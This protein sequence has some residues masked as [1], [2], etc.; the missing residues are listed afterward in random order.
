MSALVHLSAKHKLDN[1]QHLPEIARHIRGLSQNASAA[2]IEIGRSLIQAK[3][4]ARHGE[5]APWIRN[6]CGFTL[7]SAQNY[8]RAALFAVGKSETISL[9]S[10][11]AIYLLSAKST[12]PEIVSSVMRALENGRIFSETEIEDMLADRRLTRALSPD[13]SESIPGDQASELAARLLLQIDRSLAQTLIDGPWNLIGKRLRQHLLHGTKQEENVLR[14]GQ[15][16]DLG[17]PVELL[18]DPTDDCFR[19][20]EHGNSCQ[21]TLGADNQARAGGDL[22][23]ARSPTDERPAAAAPP[24]GFDDGIPEFLRRNR[25]AAEPPATSTAA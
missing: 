22:S 12:P 7:R 6:E 19:P 9:L 18:R 11:G 10:P 23:D 13:T 5:F 3:D 16:F 25:T 1:G 21:Q 2:I 14:G 20:R 15:K 8:M 4:I 24:D 17:Q